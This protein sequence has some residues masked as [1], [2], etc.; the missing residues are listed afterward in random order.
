MFDDP[1]VVRVR[2]PRKDPYKDQY[3]NVKYTIPPGG[4]VIVPW[5]AAALW[6]GDPRV[7]DDE[8][9]GLFARA[10]ELHRVLTRMGSGGLDDRRLSEA[11]R[12]RA[13]HPGIEVYD[14]DSNRIEMLVDD[15]EGE[16]VVPA[17]FV[18]A[19][20][21]D[22]YAELD[23]V[24]ALQAQLLAAIEQQQNAATAPGL[25][26]ALDDAPSKVPGPASTK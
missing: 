9:R 16:N 7:V 15:P 22:L 12:A 5:Q 10:D 6:L 11:D 24:K 20:K 3:A 26:A 4:E 18:R 2:N 23:R 13:D 14:I 19:E 21:D 8:N 25:D 1:Q 17:A